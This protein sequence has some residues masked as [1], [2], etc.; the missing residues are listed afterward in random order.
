MRQWREQWWTG[1]GPGQA[2]DDPAPEWEQE[3]ET[4]K[5]MPI[6][7]LWHVA[8]SDAQRQTVGLVQVPDLKGGEWGRAGVDVHLHIQGTKKDNHPLIKWEK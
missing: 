7:R 1:K 3:I 8:R 4:D 2:W 6:G 5:E